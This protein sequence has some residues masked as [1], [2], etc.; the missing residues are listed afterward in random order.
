MYDIDVSTC[1][2]Y[3]WCINSENDS[4]AVFVV[5]DGTPKAMYHLKDPPSK[6]QA[7]KYPQI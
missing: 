4:L 5:L 6:A 2:I 3:R 1:K 7:R